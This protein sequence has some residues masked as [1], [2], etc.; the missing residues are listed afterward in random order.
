MHIIGKILGSITLGLILSV[1]F[2]TL[3]FQGFLFERGTEILGIGKIGLSFFFGGFIASVFLMFQPGARDLKR[4]IVVYPVCGV[5]VG[6]LALSGLM[7][8]SG[9]QSFEGAEAIEQMLGQFAQMVAMLFFWGTPAIVTGIF[10]SLIWSAKAPSQTSGAEELLTAT[11]AERQQA[12]A[13][14]HS[15]VLSTKQ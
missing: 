7:A 13:A 3:M 14:P 12:D 2:G 11:E 10:A 15:A 9:A 6:S 5:V 4:L 8:E 1:V